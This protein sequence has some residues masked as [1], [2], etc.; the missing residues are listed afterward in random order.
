MMLH[1]TKRN[2][3]LA[4]MAVGRLPGLGQSPGGLGG[5][6][7]WLEESPGT[8]FSFSVPGA[9]ISIVGDRWCLCDS[10]RSQAWGAKCA[11]PY[12]AR[13]S[14][15]RLARATRAG[16]A[17]YAAAASPRLPNRFSSSRKYAAEC[18]KAPTGSNGSARPC[19]L[20]VAGMNWAIPAAPFGLT[21]T[22][23]L[24]DHPGKELDG[25]RVLRG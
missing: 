13:K 21:E 23:F 22:T 17:L 6:M 5:Q 1:G 3:I 15:P 7:R 9:A 4:S 20:A 10:G 19:Q 25:Q 11:N 2:P 12:A 18:R 16:P 14:F 24:P 8:G